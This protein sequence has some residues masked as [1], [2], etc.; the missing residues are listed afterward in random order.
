MMSDRHLIDEYIPWLER[1]RSLTET[2]VA[3]ARNV[4]RS[5]A[6]FLDERG[7]TTLRMAKIESVLAYVEKRHSIDRVKDVTV[8]DSLCILRT[9][10]N[11]LTCFGGS[12][13]PTACLPEFVCRKTYVGDYLS[14]DETFSM[15]DSCDMKEPHGLRNYCILAFLWSTG[16]RTAEFLA[17]QWRDIDL[18]EGTVLV[19]KGKG[20]KQRRL[21]LNDRLC[22]DMRRYRARI[23]GG[24]KHHVFCSAA[25]SSRAD[26]AMDRH[27]LSAVI[28]TA[29]AKAGLNRRVTPLTLRHTFA[30]HMYEAGVGIRDIQEMMGHSQLTE[31]T[32]YV[33][34]TVNAA[35]RLL[36]EH[37]YHTRHERGEPS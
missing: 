10:Y 12:S 4:L 27:E 18:D 6:D 11:Y 22:D 33:H 35:K 17:L 3:H 15:L 37:V 8:S 5:W 2:S 9:F 24:E 20:R 30:T 28:K 23:L 16:L 7:E 14:V 32:V 25:P 1:I 19:R 29:A 31:T 21:F 36:N 26:G 13:N 34:V